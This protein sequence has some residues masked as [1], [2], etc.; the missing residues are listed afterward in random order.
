MFA[1]LTPLYFYLQLIWRDD[2]ILEG[3][4]QK[5]LKDFKGSLQTAEQAEQW[6]LVNVI[7]ANLEALEWLEGSTADLE[8]V[9][10]AH[11]GQRCLN[12]GIFIYFNCNLSQY[13]VKPHSTWF[14]EGGPAEFLLAPV[15]SSLDGLHLAEH[16]QQQRGFPTTHLAH[17][18]CQLT[19]TDWKGWQSFC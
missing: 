10:A 8:S 12:Q 17:D 11:N 18:H 3:P 1:T 14:L 5:P 6:V 16:G 4:W 7:L 19:W 9:G 2:L 13:F 15:D